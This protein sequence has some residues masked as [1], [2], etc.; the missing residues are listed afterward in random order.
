[1]RT[2]DRVLGYGV[3]IALFALAS[4]WTVDRYG[5]A[6]YWPSLLATLVAVVLAFEFERRRERRAL[7]RAEESLTRRRETEARKRLLALQDELERNQISIDGIAKELQHVP[8]GV[9]ALIHPQL[10][11]GTWSSSGERLGD[12]L[13]E[14][15][16]VARVST[17][18][19]R[20]EELRWR[21][22]YRTQASDSAVDTMTLALA[23][24]MQ[25]EVAELIKKVQA[26]ERAPEVR[27]VGVTHV[28]SLSGGIRP[29]ASLTAEKVAGEPDASAGAGE[30]GE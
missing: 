2:F 17:F 26:Q 10:L 7:E 16:L 21:V 27:P 22:R 11:D 9:F 1:M 18:Y 24:E 8:P 28:A 3:G 23:V 30:D 19:G 4:T 29:T 25:P 20:L 5:G 15:D 14:Y 12:L 13:A 6:S